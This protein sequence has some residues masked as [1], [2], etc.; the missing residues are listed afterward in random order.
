[1]TVLEPPAT[2]TQLKQVKPQAAGALV[3]FE[4]DALRNTLIRAAG[5]KLSMVAESSTHTM[6]DQIQTIRQTMVEFGAI[7]RKSV[8]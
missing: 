2:A 5:N 4:E 3:D 6:G 8:V 1:M 7:D